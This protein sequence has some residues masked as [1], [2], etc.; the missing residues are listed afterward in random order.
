[1]MKNDFKILA[2]FLITGLLSG[3]APAAQ[4]NPTS[5]ET[6]VAAEAIE[7]TSYEETIPN[8]QIQ[9]KQTQTVASASSDLISADSAKAISVKDA[10]LKAENVSYSTAG[11]DWEDGRQ[12]YEVKFFADGIEYEYDILASDGTILKKQQDREGMQIPQNQPSSVTMLTIDQA[13]QKV[14]ERI[15]GVDVSSIYI[16]QDHDDGRL[17]YEGEV[18]FNQKKYEFTLDAATGNFIGWEE[19][20]N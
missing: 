3:C 7:S 2:V 20:S 11:L 10:G 1:M 15:Q 16:T 14:A 17:E 12:I 9:E 4:G 6:Y 5:A 8:S 13:K 18:F 19:E